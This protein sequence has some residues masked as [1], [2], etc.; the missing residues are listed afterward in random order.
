MSLET[1]QHAL[2]EKREDGQTRFELA[3]SGLRPAVRTGRF[4]HLR[5]F[6]LSD[7]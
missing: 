2:S 4:R 3:S 5:V 6:Q 1:Q 7:A